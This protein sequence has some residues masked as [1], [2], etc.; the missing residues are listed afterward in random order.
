VSARRDQEFTDYV[1]A[2]LGS[3]R[4]LAYL[5]CQD[6]D[7]VDDLVQAAI[8]RLYVHWGRASAVDNLDAY[9]RTILIRVFLRDRR[10]GWATRVSLNAELPDAASVAADHDGAIDVRAALRTLPPRQRATLVLRFY[11]DLTVEQAARLLG[12]SGGTVRSQTAKGLAA[13]RMTLGPAEA[14]RPAGAGRA[15]DAVPP[16]AID[17]QPQM[18]P[19]TGFAHTEVT[20]HG[21]DR[22]PSSA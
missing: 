8:T 22:R 9:T 11:C 2:R 14:V 10:S 18:R 1:A 13:L 12:C 17:R 3:L 15:A 21:R 5:L 19:N 4:R 16:A 6:A 7:H 20:D